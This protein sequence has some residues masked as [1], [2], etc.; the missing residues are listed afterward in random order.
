MP[1]WKKKSQ[2]PMPINQIKFLISLKMPQLF[3]WSFEEALS[4]F[5]SK[6]NNRENPNTLNRNSVRSKAL[7]ISATFAWATK[8]H[9]FLRVCVSY[10]FTPL[11]I[12]SLKK[13]EQKIFISPIACSKYVRTQFSF[14]VGFEF[15]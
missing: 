9:S 4:V 5:L 7:Y 14:K 8:I 10:K 12:I 13:E 11:Q 15:F 2:K 3:F 6:K 1:L